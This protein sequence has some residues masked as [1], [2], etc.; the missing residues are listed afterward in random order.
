MHT[1]DW[2]IVFA[3]LMGPVLAVQI[4][5]FLDRQNERNRRQ[6]EVYR[7]LMATRLTP[8]SPEHVNALNAVPLEFH[9]NEQVVNA[10]RDM[11]MHLNVDQQANPQTWF[12]RRTQL[13]IELLKRM[14][15][16]LHYNFREAEL[17]DHAYIPQW[18]V[19]LMSEQ[20][21][22]RKGLV[23]LLS[24]TTSLSMNV[25][26]FPADEELA[27]LVKQ[28]QTM[29]V[30]WLEGKR[31]PTIVTSAEPPNARVGANFAP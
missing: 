27:K 13:F 24:G 22:L 4:Q 14:G 8:N 3:T 23:D 6:V 2:A 21:A 30:E 28:V 18:Q 5:R 31:T 12:E 15:N 20:Q 26:S 7:V 9:R 17:Q 16:A 29:M 11:L 25:K 10:W 19:A 1:A